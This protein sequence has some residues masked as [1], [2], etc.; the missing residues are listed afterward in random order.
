MYRQ[1]PFSEQMQQE[2]K[3]KVKNRFNMESGLTLPCYKLNEIIRMNNK[4]RKIPTIVF[5]K[6]T[7]SIAKYLEAILTLRSDWYS[8]SESVNSAEKIFVLLIP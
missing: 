3:V 4:D 8:H 5:D 6:E 2:A 7:I 1:Y